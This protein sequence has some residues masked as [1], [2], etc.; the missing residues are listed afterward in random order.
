LLDG[1]PV[2][3]WIARAAPVLAVG[4]LGLYVALSMAGAGQMPPD[5]GIYYSA[6]DFNN[7]YGRVWLADGDYVYAPTFAMALAP[8]RLLGPAG[9][10][11]AWTVLLFVAFA[12]AG[13]WLAFAVVLAGFVLTPAVGGS[14]PV[15]LPLLYLSIGNAQALIAA[16][17]VLGFRWP[18][19]WSVVVL[20]KLLPGIGIL[21]FLVRREW[22][23]LGVAIGATVGLVAISWVIAPA[24]WPSYVG[25]LWENR[26]TSS[27]HELVPIPLWICLPAAVAMIVWGARTDRRWTLPIACGIASLALYQWSYVVI[28]VGVAALMPS[29][30]LSRAVAPVLALGRRAGGTTEA[31]ARQLAPGMGRFGSLSRV[32]VAVHAHPL[33]RHSPTDP[34]I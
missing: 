12:V 18:A 33:E 10:V 5:T 9:F 6:G 20:T 1:V 17:I 8:L 30:N 15:T 2:S 7:L 3:R 21:W 11:V 4:V 29:T 24:A 27:T 13:R 28:W 16:A 22:R 25:F 26:G 31:F 23:S 19:L 32:P 14:T 34:P